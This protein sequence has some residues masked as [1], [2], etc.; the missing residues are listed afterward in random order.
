MRKCGTYRPLHIYGVYHNSTPMEHFSI[1]HR[2]P[3]KI[4]LD[5]LTVKNGP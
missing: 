2:F 4:A 3:T 1:C 5:I